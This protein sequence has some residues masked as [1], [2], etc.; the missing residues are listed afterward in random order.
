MVTQPTKINLQG[1]ASAQSQRKYTAAEAMD[2]GDI[3]YASSATQVSKA[4]PAQVNVNPLY[5]LEEN[6]FGIR[7]T[8]AYVEADELAGYVIGDTAEMY[9]PQVNAQWGF[10]VY[11]EGVVDLNLTAGQKL[12][13][14][15]TEAGKLGQIV[16][17]DATI[18]VGTVIAE[19]IND[20]TIPATSSLLCACW[21][22]G[23]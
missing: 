1:T 2:P 17:L 9:R 4:A 23:Q 15:A 11:N 13:L 16:T 22:V 8:T 18:V 20:V 3:V 7:E 10:N 21:Y 12:G 6:K 5:L 19:L 14:H